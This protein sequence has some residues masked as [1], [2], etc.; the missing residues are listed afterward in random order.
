M[1]AYLHT[2]EPGY[3]P[4]LRFVDAQEG[5]TLRIGDVERSSVPEPVA[6]LPRHARVVD[7]GGLWKSALT[8]QVMNQRPAI[9]TIYL[10]KCRFRGMQV[11]AREL[12]G[13]AR[14]GS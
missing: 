3:C 11:P 5:H 8:D 4:E 10:R 14:R 1:V 7:D 2:V 13:S 12:C 9:E 6:L